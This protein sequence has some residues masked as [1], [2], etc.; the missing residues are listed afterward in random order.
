MDFNVK[1]ISFSAKYIINGKQN[2]QN[3]SQSKKRTAILANDYI[4]S[5]LMQK[6]LDYL[7]DDTYVCL[8]L[9]QEDNKYGHEAPYLEFKTNSINEKINMEK[10][11][12][13]IDSLELS[14]NRDGDLNKNPI[15]KFF[16]NLIDFYYEQK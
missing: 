16:Y 3:L 6:Y 5:S 8:N 15:L 1:N 14:L 10:S 4:S 9:S 11:P 13:C 2:F 7:P 12:F